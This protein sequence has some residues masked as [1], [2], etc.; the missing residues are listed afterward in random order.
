MKW[1]VLN[2]FSYLC[3][4]RTIMV[5]IYFPRKS[6]ANRLAPHVFAQKG[7][8]ISILGHFFCPFPENFFES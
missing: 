5:C 6:S 1:F 2:S 8:D 3:D 4:G 7:F